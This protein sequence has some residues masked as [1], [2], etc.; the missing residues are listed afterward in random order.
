M[1]HPVS[2]AV[3]LDPVPIAARTLRTYQPPD[4][5]HHDEELVVLVGD[6]ELH[7]PAD[8]PQGTSPC[9]VWR[10]GGG[11]GEGSRRD[12]EGPRIGYGA[13]PS[14]PTCRLWGRVGASCLL[15]SGQWVEKGIDEVT[16]Q[17]KEGLLAVLHM[18]R[19]SHCRPSYLHQHP[20]LTLPGSPSPA[21]RPPQGQRG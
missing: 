12:T 14:P 16:L 1:G 11:T 19:L 21:P 20:Q 13:H 4:V 8:L 5:H 9:G 7:L 10:G 18:P 6:G 3:G 15:I 2:L 17:G